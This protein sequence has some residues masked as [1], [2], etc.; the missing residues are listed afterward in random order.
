MP[1][2]ESRD[3][4]AAP[5]VEDAEELPTKSPRQRFLQGLAVMAGLGALLGTCVAVVLALGREKLF[6]ST[7]LIEIHP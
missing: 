2:P 4:E 7:A 6:E 1:D 3:P 5:R